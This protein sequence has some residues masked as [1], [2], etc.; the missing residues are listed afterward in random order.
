MECMTKFCFLTASLLLIFL[1]CIGCQHICLTPNP[2]IDKDGYSQGHILIV[3]M[4]GMGDIGLYNK[5]GYFE[6][7]WSTS[8][9][10]MYGELIGAD[11][12]LVVH[13]N[14]NFLDDV[15]YLH[16]NTGL[17]AIYNSNGIMQ[18]SF[19][20]ISLHH[21]IAIKNPRRIFALS[22][23]IKNVKH[24]NKTV[25]IVDD[26]IVEIDLK[27]K[28]IVKKLTLSD[29]FPV[30]DQLPKPKQLY[31]NSIDLFHANA[32]DYIKENP[33]NGSEAILVT[34]R[35]FQRGTIA[36]IDLQTN[37]LLW[38]SPKGFFLYPH[39]GKFTKDKTITVFDN[40]DQYRLRSRIFEMDIKT[41]KI[42]WE[43]DGAKNENNMLKEWGQLTKVEK[44]LLSETWT[45]WNELS[46][47]MSGVQKTEKG[48]LISSGMQG[49]IYEVSRDHKIVWELP[50]GTSVFRSSSLRP[51]T[52]IFKA[53][54][55]NLD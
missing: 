41:N 40:G 39:D 13:K 31:R 54:Q 50:A 10:T 47:Y 5:K 45:K 28:T 6:K 35:N 55:Y 23:K 34:M 15:S 21:D 52:K 17:I 37:E 16:T 38:Q 49:T 11:E 51:A 1:F 26:S 20:D 8:D 9:T 7:I 14:K 27:T 19:E 18:T 33:V 44:N 22:L 29:Y 53:R 48:Y 46:L 12:I 2:I 32:I 3:P 43:Y 24:K 42:L 4:G 25:R 30:P 36:L